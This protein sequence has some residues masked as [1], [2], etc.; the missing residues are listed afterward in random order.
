MNLIITVNY[1]KADTTLQFIKSIPVQ[2]NIELWIEDNQSTSNSFKTLVDAQS[3]EP[4]NISIFPH[5]QNHYYWGVL[6]KDY[7]GYL[8]V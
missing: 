4:L 8:S 6:I 1:G 5:K 7:P 3:K 2:K